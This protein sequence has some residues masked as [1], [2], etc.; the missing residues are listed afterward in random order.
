MVHR[1]CVQEAQ[2]LV[3]SGNDGKCYLL[4]AAARDKKKATTDIACHCR[5][6]RM[7]TTEMAEELVL[8]EAS[9]AYTHLMG[10][11]RIVCRGAQQ[12]VGV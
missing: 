8:A 6:S 2:D 5:L 3:F 11:A 9:R 7:P 12:A 1:V 10:G 4:S